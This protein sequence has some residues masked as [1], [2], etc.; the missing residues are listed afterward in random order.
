MIFFSNWPLR[1]AI[2]V[3]NCS[4][5]IKKEKHTYKHKDRVLI[6]KNINIRK[7]HKWAEILYLT[8]RLRVGVSKR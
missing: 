3:M 5:K 6:G 7:K 1:D 4:K 2:V 8:G